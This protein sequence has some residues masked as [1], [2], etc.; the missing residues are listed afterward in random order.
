[1]P[2]SAWSRLK[3]DYCGRDKARAICRVPNPHEYDWRLGLPNPSECLRNMI[4]HCGLGTPTEVRKK[5][6]AYVR[7]LLRIMREKRIRLASY[8]LRLSNSDSQQ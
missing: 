5:F 3:D 7:D 4:H 1:M 6:G 2:L 8:R